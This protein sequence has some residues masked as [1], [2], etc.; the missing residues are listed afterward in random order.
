MAP[1]DNHAFQTPATQPASNNHKNGSTLPEQRNCTMNT[2]NETNPVEPTLTLDQVVLVSGLT[3]NRIAEMMEVGE[4][5]PPLPTLPRYQWATDTL[6]TW[7]TAYDT[8]KAI[9]RREWDNREE[10]FFGPRAL[11]RW[12]RKS[13]VE[14]RTF[15]LEEWREAYWAA[16]KEVFDARNARYEAH[17][18]GTDQW[19]GM[20]DAEES[21]GFDLKDTAL[22]RIEKVLAANE[23]TSNHGIE[24]LVTP[25][26]GAQC[27]E[28]GNSHE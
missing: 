9:N 14:T 8:V 12:V 1:H 10:D 22:V 23:P 11:A 18:I 3:R 20:A 27:D 16:E 15:L 17:L 28:E 6:R 21:C 26:T 7:L 5:P 24:T 25:E 2:Q 4:F 13:E 19:I